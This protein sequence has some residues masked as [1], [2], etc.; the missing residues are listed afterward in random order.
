MANSHEYKLHVN[1][2]SNLINKTKQT[3]EQNGK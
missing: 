2:N 3:K 1:K